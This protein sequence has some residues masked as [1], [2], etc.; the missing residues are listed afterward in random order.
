MDFHTV[1]KVLFF[2]DVNHLNNYGRPIVGDDYVALPHGPVPQTT[3]DILK[4]DP[5]IRDALQI[6]FLPFTVVG[7]YRVEAQRPPDLDLLSE[8]DLAALEEAWTKCAD[9]GF[10]ERS[11][12]SHQHPAWR[13]ARNAGRHLMDYAD[14]LEGENL[15]PE[16]I[17]DIAEFA[18]DLRG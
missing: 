14:F 15:T 11:A 6:D 12:V 8:S 7:G 2:A 3:Y 1:L 16:R 5:L 4:G 18:A 13:N 10:S 9:L 17:N